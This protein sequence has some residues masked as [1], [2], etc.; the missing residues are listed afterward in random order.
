MWRSSAA[1]SVWPCI[2]CGLAR[3]KK[4]RFH[5][6][7]ILATTRGAY[8][9][10]RSFTPKRRPSKQGD[11]RPVHAWRACE[12]LDRRSLLHLSVDDGPRILVSLYVLAGCNRGG[13]PHGAIL[14]SLAW[15]GF[16]GVTLLDL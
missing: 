12:S 3:R 6:M 1:S 5:R 4:N 15:A 14:A 11:H 16:Y 2:T 10:R 7:M 8:D 13:R 9:D